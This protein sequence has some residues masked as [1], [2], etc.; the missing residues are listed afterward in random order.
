MATKI[1]KKC[2]TGVE[3]SNFNK[4]SR[5]P[6][7]L[8]VYCRACR[9]DAR[10]KTYKAHRDEEIAVQ[11]VYDKV[12]ANRRKCQSIS[13]KFSKD[14]PKGCDFHH[15]CYHEPHSLIILDER[16]HNRIHRM[17]TFDDVE[18]MFIVEKTGELLDTLDKHL[19][20]IRNYANEMR[21][22][23]IIGFFDASRC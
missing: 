7:G 19:A 9:S 20:F 17:L 23:H 18:Q 6:D 15:W 8:D 22:S 2:G 12:Y 3:V 11:S 13:R 21:D 1:C 5:K 10:K 14:K 4:D 16:T